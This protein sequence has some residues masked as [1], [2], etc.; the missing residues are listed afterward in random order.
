MAITIYYRIY[1]TVLSVVFGFWAYYRDKTKFIKVAVLR[2]DVF[3]DLPPDSPWAISHQLVTAYRL[4]CELESLFNDK[5]RFQIN[6]VI[7]RSIIVFTIMQKLK[8]QMAQQYFQNYP[9][10][11]YYMYIVVD[12]LVTYIQ[13]VVVQNNEAWKADCSGLRSKPLKAKICLQ[14][15]QYSTMLVGSLR[16]RRKLGWKI[17][18]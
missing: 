2:S 18:T 17:I 10:L 4:F 6:K 1:H 15:G 11:I 3:F 12:L 13:Y 9:Y 14:H 16:T 5:M 7:L 8:K